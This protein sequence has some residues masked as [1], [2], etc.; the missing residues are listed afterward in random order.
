MA[1]ESEVKKMLSVLSMSREDNLYYSFVIGA[2][3]VRYNLSL[4]DLHIFTE[5]FSQIIE[6]A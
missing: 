4:K 2:V 3:S 5:Q 6:L 1:E